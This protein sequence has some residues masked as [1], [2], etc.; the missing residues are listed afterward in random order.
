MFTLNICWWVKCDS[1][2]IRQTP[3][4]YQLPAEV[5][6]MQVVYCLYMNPVCQVNALQTPALCLRVFTHQPPKYKALNNWWVIS[7]IWSDWKKIN[8]LLNMK[9]SPKDLWF[10][11]QQLS[12]LIE[13]FITLKPFK[14]ETWLWILRVSSW[15]NE[16][17]DFEKE[18]IL[19]HQNLY[20]NAATRWW[21]VRLH[22]HPHLPP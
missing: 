20:R 15:A 8:Q 4:L 12:D 1:L 11:N 3:G 10:S 13:Y 2:D 17:F 9:Q 21:V 14:S 16:G 6:D 18:K 19:H 22:K 7:G 5:K